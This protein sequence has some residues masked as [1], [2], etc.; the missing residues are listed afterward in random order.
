M[1]ELIQEGFIAFLLLTRIKPITES[2]ASCLIRS[3]WLFQFGL[4]PDV[5]CPEPGVHLYMT[6]IFSKTCHTVQYAVM[7]V[8]SARFTQR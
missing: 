7:K 8:F 6:V 3:A 5:D 2:H 4:T 1:R